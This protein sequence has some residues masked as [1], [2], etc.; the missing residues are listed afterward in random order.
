MVERLT[1]SMIEERFEEAASTL[2]RLPNSHVPGYFNT[3][4]VIV[5]SAFEAFGWN[6]RA[7]LA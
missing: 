1:P 7:C 2:R 6:A 5:R 3:W 4:P